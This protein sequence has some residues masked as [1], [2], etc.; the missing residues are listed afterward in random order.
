M[1]VSFLLDYSGLSG[2]L[3]AVVLSI[4]NSL[5]NFW[6]SRIR[7]RVIFWIASDRFWR[8]KPI[9]WS[10]LEV[11]VANACD[12]E[13]AKVQP[14]PAQSF[15]LTV[16]QTVRR[17]PINLPSFS[18]LRVPGSIGEIKIHRVAASGASRFPLLII[19]GSRA[20]SPGSKVKPSQR[21]VMTNAHPRG[22]FPP[23]KLWPPC[24][25]Q[26][27]RGAPGQGKRPAS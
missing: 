21:H 13:Q 20:Y 25:A 6:V 4:P 16:F 10:A 17:L 23:S 7:I 22:D 1:P 8:Q 15:R 14:R 2:P 5:M 24:V 18:R 19:S 11:H 27:T 12:S 26:N 3:F 9:A